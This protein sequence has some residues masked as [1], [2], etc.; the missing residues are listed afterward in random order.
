[1]P[2]PCIHDALSATSRLEHT[3]EEL[4][5][6]VI[7]SQHMETLRRCCARAARSIHLYG[8]EAPQEVSQPISDSMRLQEALAPSAQTSAKN[9]TPRDRQVQN[10]E[11]KEDIKMGV[12]YV[13]AEAAAKYSNLNLNVL[14][15]TYWHPPLKEQSVKGDG[16]AAGNVS[17]SSASNS[18][19]GAAERALRER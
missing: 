19:R 15:A 8:Q 7:K 6:R 9:S 13:S 16:A 1:M 5:L 11:K 2:L 17:S 4:S 18:A 3:S 10:A 14:Q 12:P